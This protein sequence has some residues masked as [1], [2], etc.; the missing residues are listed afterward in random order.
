VVASKS[1]GK[2]SL[3]AAVPVTRESGVVGA[4]GCSIFLDELSTRLAS[5]IDLPSDMVFWATNDEDD[6]VL[7]SDPDMILDEDAELP[8]TGVFQTSLL[9]DWRF[10]LAFED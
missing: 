4:V 6:I 8:A 2:A 10:G 3:I 1:T 9:L 7:H 5:D